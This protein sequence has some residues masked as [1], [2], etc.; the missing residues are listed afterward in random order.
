MNHDTSLGDPTPD[1]A[2][3]AGG[4]F[5]APNGTQPL[6]LGP[7]RQWTIEEI[8]AEAKLPELR[9]RICL[10]A[11]LQERHDSI[12]AE[13]ATLVD[14]RGELIEDDEATAGDVTNASRARALND[15]LQGVQREMAKSMWFPLFRGMASDDLAVFSK[16]HLP[17]DASDPNAKVDMTTYNTLL[18][19]ECSVDPKLS[20]DD[21]KALRKKLGSRAMGELVKTATRVCTQGGVDVPKSPV[22][23]RN[24]TQE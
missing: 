2:P 20:V 6:D 3:P 4:V 1:S 11:D 7:I 16:L 9:A 8:L 23:L 12:L 10:R 5:G 13:L 21:V 24:L 15:E 14:A 18:V 19:A 17:K 22:S